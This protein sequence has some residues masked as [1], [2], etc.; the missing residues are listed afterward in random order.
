MMQIDVERGQEFRKCIECFMCQDVCHV[1]RDHEENKATYAG[2]RYF[3]RYM[4][5]ESHPLD[6]NDRR[7]L[8]R[9][10]MGLGYVQHHQVLHR[11]VPGAHQDHRQRHH[12]SERAGRRRVVRPR[13]MAREEGARPKGCSPAS[14]AYGREPDPSASECRWRSRNFSGSFGRRGTHPG[15]IDQD[16]RHR[17]IGRILGPEG[18]RARHRIRFFADA[19]LIPLRIVALLKAN[20]RGIGHFRFRG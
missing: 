17:R 13:C 12:P 5:L 20:V 19:E 4:E 9:K 16:R 3:I 10:R 2:P 6:T 15:D 14:T 11:G 1:I 7:E 8:M 18:H